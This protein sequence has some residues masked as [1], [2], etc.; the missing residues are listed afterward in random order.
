MAVLL[1]RI[2]ILRHRGAAAALELRVAFKA[3]VELMQVGDVWWP[4]AMIGLGAS[5]SKA[6]LSC[7]SLRLQCGSDIK[8]EA[9]EVCLVA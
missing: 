7:I 8:L 5:P 3:A 6:H 4:A 9:L 2:D 1:A